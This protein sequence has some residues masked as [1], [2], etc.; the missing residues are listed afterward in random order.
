[1]KLL[2]TI[3]LLLICSKMS[4]QENEPPPAKLLTSFKFEQL[5]GGIVILRATL[6]KFPDTL[7]FILDTGSGG[8]SLD[9]LTALYYK[10]PIENSDRTVRG[11]GGVKPLQYYK[12]GTLHFKG[13]D[14]EKLDFHINDYE[15]L[16]E[17]YGLRVDGIIGFS[18]FRR[19][20]VGLD[21]DKQTISV[22]TPGKYKYP[23]NGTYL[24]P[25][26]A[27][28]PV[29]RHEVIDEKSYLLNFYFDTGAGLCLLF[30]EQFMRDNTFISRKKKS[31][32]TQV[33]GLMGKISMRLTSIKKMKLG[34]Y[35]FNRVPVHV[36]DD[37]LNVLGYPGISGLLGSDLLR[38]FNLVINYPEKIIHLT[39]NS[40]MKDPFDYSYTGM[41]Y[42][43]I[44]GKIVITEVQQGSP[45]EKAG[46]LPGDVIFGVDNNF[47][48]SIQQYKALM[49]TA[50]EKLRILIF[51]NTQPR[52]IELKV[53]SILK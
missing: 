23:R 15:I 52:L 45:A 53:G 25:T 17:V 29:T 22:Y 39:P 27:N 2:K 33:E 41:N 32:S 1:M 12:N 10:L 18:F 19:Y 30:T 46:F 43:F 3:C 38:R 4:A 42:Y 35:K 44:E 34:P 51:R 11:I 31:V 26:F 16:S 21:Y 50:G 8:I 47:S 14:V 40:H 24:A 28:I 49:Q 36:Y 6:D 5:T 48:N 20:I 9:T 37:S 7:N 13:L